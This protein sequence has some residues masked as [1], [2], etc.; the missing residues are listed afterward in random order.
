MVIDF[1]THILP[2]SI[3]SNREAYLAKDTTLGTLF[4]TDTNPMASAEDLIATMDSDGIDASVI[5]GLGWTNLEV[6][7][8]VNDYLLE[9][10]QRYPGR[11]LP[12]CSVNPM[13]GDQGLE[14]IERCVGLG[15]IGVGELHP[16]LQGYKLT[17]LSVITPMM[18]L[19]QKLNLIVLVHTSEPVGHQYPGKGTSTPDVLWSFIEQFPDLSL[20]CAHWGGGLPFYALMPEVRKALGKVYFDTAV[21]PFLYDERIFSVVPKLSVVSSILMGSDFPLVRPKRLIEQVSTSELSSESKASILGGNAH[22][23]LRL[24]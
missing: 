6:A 13:W 9:S 3:L 8:Q 16:D 4:I 19:A 2:P 11:L 1:H 10:A 15:A 7:K 14:E 18:L 5:L 21:S 17:D 22:A 12:F 20:V 24:P 23:L